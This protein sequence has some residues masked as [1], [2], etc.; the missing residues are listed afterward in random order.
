MIDIDLVNAD[1]QESLG[2]ASDGGGGAA[3]PTGP[4][5]RV[6]LD[7]ES[8]ELDGVRADLAT[9]VSRCKAAR[10]ADV[11]TGAAIIGAVRDLLLALKDAGVV[12]KA[13]PDLWRVAGLAGAAE[14]SSR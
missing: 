4:P 5:C 6:R 2:R 3:R 1:L 9:E 7:V 13:S 10:A 8:L 14:G 11:A 12:V